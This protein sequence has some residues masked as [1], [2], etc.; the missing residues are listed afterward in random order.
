M[1]RRSVLAAAA[2]CALV[3]ALAAEAAPPADGPVLAI[4]RPASFTLDFGTLARGQIASRELT[5]HNPGTAPLEVVL[6]APGAPFTA[7]SSASIAR[8]ATET[9]QIM[10]RSDV[11]VPATDAEVTLTSN[12]V[13]SNTAAID[14]RCAVADTRLEVVP[15][16]LDFAEVRLGAM[17]PT[18]SITLRNPG[19]GAMLIERIQ[20]AAAH[21]N[22]RL[23]PELTKDLSLPAGA[24]HALT[25]SLAPTAELSLDGAKLAIDVDGVALALP[26]AG[27]VVTPSARVSPGALDLGTACVGT[28]V[29]GAVRLVNSGTATL[30][31]QEPT[32]DRS[33]ATLLEHPASY[34]APLAPGFAATVGVTPRTAQIG[35]IDGLLTWDVDAPAGPFSVPVTLRYIDAGTAISPRSLIFGS[36]DAGQATPKQTVTLENCNPQPIRLAID[37]VRAAQGDLDAWDVSPATDERTLGPRDKLQLTAVFRPTR[38]GRH[39]AYVQLAIDGEPGEIE[40]SGD[41]LGEVPEPTSFYACD[42]QSPGSPAA[43]G[44]LVLAVLLVLR[45]RRPRPP[46]RR[47]IPAMLAPSP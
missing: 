19:P 40:L 31:M 1:V 14:V 47:L 21:P 30:L 37:G 16:T 11:P 34:P 26:I 15:G 5:I 25:L 36:I 7:P 8:G 32:L 12:A 42:C 6:G 43:G 13:Q 29:T 44:S 17:P 35:P 3:R 46:R 38:V 39:V 20:L 23:Q 28:Q 24:T 22:L 45:R 2:A 9:L 10:C 4:T 41:A 27:A 33:F 18:I